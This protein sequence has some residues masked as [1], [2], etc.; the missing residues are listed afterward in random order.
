MSF[1]ILPVFGGKYKVNET[2][3]FTPTKP[4]I[5]GDCKWNFISSG[6]DIVAR[7][8][9]TTVE[10]NFESKRTFT[11]KALKVGK[12]T[13]RFLKPLRQDKPG[14]ECSGQNGDSA[15]FEVEIT[16]S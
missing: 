14:S 6:N 3:T 8:G 15:N 5:M 4:E 16:G 12:Q 2:F 9:E 13:L 10:S 1:L 7:M 11:F